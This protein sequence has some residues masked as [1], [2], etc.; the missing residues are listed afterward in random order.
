MMNEAFNA[1]TVV[2]ADLGPISGT[3]SSWE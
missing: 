1:A 3:L 2:M